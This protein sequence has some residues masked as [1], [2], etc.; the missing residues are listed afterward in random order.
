LSFWEQK[1][2]MLTK[3]DGVFY[4]ASF[5]QSKTK[6]YNFDNLVKV[7]IFSFIKTLTKFCTFDKSG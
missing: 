1:L 6:I 3:S 5:D 2:R 7:R 4:E